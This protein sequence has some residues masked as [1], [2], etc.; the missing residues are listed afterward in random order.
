MTINTQELDPGASQIAFPKDCAYEVRVLR[1]LKEIESVRTVWCAMQW[2]PEADIDFVSFIV[3]TR[4][5]ILHPYVVVVS[6]EGKPVSLFA[7]RIENGHLPIKIGYKT[8]FRPKV[9]QLVIFYG[10]FMGDTSRPLCEIVVRQLL[11]SL[12]QR[13]AEML[14]WGGVGWESDLKDVLDKEPAWFC[15]DH[16]AR[17]SEHWSLTLPGSLEEFIDQRLGKRSRQWARKAIRTLN[18]EFSGEIRY[19]YF[20]SPEETKELIAHATTISQKT[21]QHGLGVGFKNDEEHLNRLNL[22]AQLGWLRG[23]VLFLK[24]KPVAFWSALEY[25]ETGYLAFTGY[26]PDY[27]NYDVGSILFFHMIEDICRKNPKHIKRLDFGLGTSYYKSRFCDEKLEETTI[28]VFASSPRA[29]L[30]G[31]LRLVTVGPMEMVANFFRGLGLE[32]KIK[33]LWRARAIRR[34]QT[35]N[36]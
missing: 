34:Q 1:S 10:G 18:K 32:A 12:K 5:N 33:K 4:T 7:A 3:N 27:H 22:E 24:N 6:K 36:Q 29:V 28:C 14:V 20:S 8:L 16:L 23:Y 25:R 30:L 19:G 15:R 11:E 17:S 21:Y 35:A 2:C 31:L 26:D 13:E 9:R